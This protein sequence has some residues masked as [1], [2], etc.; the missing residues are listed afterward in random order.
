M[1]FNVVSIATATDEDG[2]A[3][4]VCV[5]TSMAQAVIGAPFIVTVAGMGQTSLN[6]TSGPSLELRHLVGTTHDCWLCQCGLLP[7]D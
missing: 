5:R 6:H 7:V 4:F 2:M 3:W 1:L